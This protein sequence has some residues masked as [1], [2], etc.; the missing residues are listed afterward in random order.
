M[1]IVITGA[2]SMIG[3][4][5]IR[6]ALKRN[7]EITCIVNPT[8]TRISS[9]PNN[10]KIHIIKCDIADYNNLDIKPSENSEYFFNLAWPYSAGELRDNVEYQLKNIN[11][12]IDAVK[13]CKKFGCKKFIGA[14]S[15]AEYGI[16]SE[17]LSSTTA[18]NPENAFGIAKYTSGKLASILCK[19]YKID[20]NWLRILSVYGPGDRKNSLI[21]YVVDELK[22][23][24]SPELTKCE[25]TWDY[26]HCDDA[27]DAFFA[28]AEHGV[29]GK[30]YPLGSGHGRKLSEYVNELQALIAPNVSLCY[31]KK[32]YYPSQPMYLVSQNEEL[33]TDTGWQ[34]LIKFSEGIK[35][36]I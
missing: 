3:L 16:K 29:D 4:A 22:N 14:G 8:S 17:S 20:F 34:P 31:G 21:N 11:Y 1:K 18:I 27:A 2:T 30:I 26:L 23:G 36:I 32:S 6:N 19:Q 9:I 12:V 25:Q 33:T 28:V 5:I 7:C 13:L 15:Q 35:T 24:H 10:E